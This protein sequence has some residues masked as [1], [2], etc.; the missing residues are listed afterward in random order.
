M[1]I[2][3]L[4]IGVTACLITTMAFAGCGT[5]NLDN[6][7]ISK[8]SDVSSYIQNMNF[9]K[10]KVLA[11]ELGDKIKLDNGKTYDTTTSSEGV[12]LIVTHKE[13]KTVENGSADINVMD[14]NSSAI[15]PG[16]VLKCDSNLL[17]GNPTPDDLDRGD[18]NI[19]LDLNGATG[20]QK[21][22]V[23]KATKGNVEEKINQAVAS[24][25]TTG[26]QVAANANAKVIQVRN[27]QTLEAEIGIKGIAS[28]F[29]IS[30]GAKGKTEKNTYIISYKQTYFN[31]TIDYNYNESSIYASN[32]TLDDVKQRYPLDSNGDCNTPPVLINNVSY[33]R[34][35]YLKV[36]TDLTMAEINAAFKYLQKVDEKDPKKKQQMELELR[37]KFNKTM[38]NST[39][40]YLV[41]GGPNS[42]AGLLPIGSKP[43][44]A[45][46]KVIADGAIFTGETGYKIISYST[47]FLKDNTAA[48]VN[49]TSQYIEETRKVL[50]QQEI[51]VENQGCYVVKKWNIKARKITGWD[52][53]GNP[54]FGELET[55]YT[56]NKT[57]AR[58]GYTYFIDANYGRVEFEYDIHRGSDW[59]FKGRITSADFFQKADIYTHGT[60]HFNSVEL[61]VDGTRRRV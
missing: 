1:K 21:Q 3:A 59:P 47:H 27:S 33:G 9:D 13:V 20:T 44:E 36:E 50:T 48:T 25:A 10:D 24:W 15:Y 53:K 31:A 40:N 2:R 6:I 58:Q 4:M 11:M 54:I 55:L 52:E 35:V 49:A 34:M 51:Y 26:K 12:K 5:T 37:E 60:I 45:I 41:Y 23:V 56:R 8:I 19:I 29:G 7:V 22:F 28:K 46:Q 17:S 39:I 30:I 14:S 38:E 16:G 18:V 32:V 42:G 43:A 61:I 57:V